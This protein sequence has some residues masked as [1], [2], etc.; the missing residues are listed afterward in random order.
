MQ[1]DLH[2]NSIYVGVHVVQVQCNPEV[3]KVVRKSLLCLG[4]KGYEMLYA[5]R[6]KSFCTC[7]TEKM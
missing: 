6:C 3:P 1:Q 2:I 7:N 5:V 4:T